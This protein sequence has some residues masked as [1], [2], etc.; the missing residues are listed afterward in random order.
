MGMRYKS[1][2]V[3]MTVLTVFE[4]PASHNLLEFAVRR[5]G[6]SMIRAHSYETAHAI[7]SVDAPRMVICEQTMGDRR[8]QDLL[9]VES[10]R[11]GSTLVIVT[12]GD[13]DA[14]LWAEVL[15][16]GGY[17]VL[18]QPFDELEVVRL[19]QFQEEAIYAI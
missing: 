9:E 10:V 19:L 6:W 12:S 14:A 15:N 3:E 1:R 5:A 13:T 17:D 18:P 7:L 16:L 11:T 8:W 4:S 2:S